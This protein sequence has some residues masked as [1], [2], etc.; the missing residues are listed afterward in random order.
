MGDKGFLP[1]DW[2]FLVDLKSGLA[3]GTMMPSDS[4]IILDCSLSKSHCC[5]SSSTSSSFFLLINSFFSPVIFA[6]ILKKCY[7]FYYIFNFFYKSLSIIS[8]SFRF[9]KESI[10]E[11]E[12]RPIKFLNFFFFFVY[13]FKFFISSARRAGLSSTLAFSFTSSESFSVW[14]WGEKNDSYLPIEFLVV[15]RIFLA[16]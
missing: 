8:P 6:A 3:V 9:G 7:C 4:L 12:L 15:H 2:D 13:A 11:W 1:G 10:I 5:I 16:F 14:V